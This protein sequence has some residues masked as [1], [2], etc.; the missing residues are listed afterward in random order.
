M[1]QKSYARR[2]R[3]EQKKQTQEVLDENNCWDDLQALYS[4]AAKALGAH[5][6]IGHLMNKKEVLPY[7]GQN[8]RPVAEAITALTRDIEAMN[9]ELLALY[10]LHAD[11]RGGTDNPDEVMHS[12]QLGEQYYLFMT[13]HDNVIMPNVFFVLEQMDLA[14]QA[15]ER[16]TKAAQAAEQIKHTPVTLEAEVTPVNE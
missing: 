7:L 1:T 11:K 10:A 14:E 16:A 6:G 2:M 13:R 9:G 4:E 5:A 3:D 12:L 8:A 15:Y